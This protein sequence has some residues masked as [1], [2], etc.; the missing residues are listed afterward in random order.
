MSNVMERKPD[1]QVLSHYE[2]V[3]RPGERDLVVLLF[4]A[5]G[6]RIMD[7]GKYVSG[8]VGQAAS[9]NAVENA[10][11]ASEITPEHWDFEQ[12]LTAELQQPHLA[13]RSQAY[14][15]AL[16]AAPQNRPHFG[17]AF[18]SLDSWT[19]AVERVQRA[20]EE[21]PRLMGRAEL[22]SKFYPGSPG[23]QTD[24]LHHAF[25]HTDIIGT[26]CLALGLII[27]FQFYERHPM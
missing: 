2:T 7:E 18:S 8:F 22:A 5:L 27:E 12:V 4:E 20:I 19:A 11:F 10:I 3:Y 17:I 6:L 21:Q 26:S 13:G 25:I 1:N 24:Y 16:K 9:G 23:A 14:V 15:Q